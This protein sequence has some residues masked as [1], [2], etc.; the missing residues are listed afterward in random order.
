MKR[1]FVVSLF[2]AFLL[3]SSV[4]A[5]DAVKVEKGKKVK[6]D[7][8]LKVDG[9]VVE[10]SVGK[11][12]LEYTQGA[13]MIIP[14]LES[15]LEGMKVGDQKTVTVAPKDGYGEINPE[16]VK[17][18]P[19]SAFPADFTPQVGMVIEMKDEKS[20]QTVPA[21]IQEIKDGKVKLNFNHPMAGKTLVFDVKIIDIK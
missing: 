17:D 10:S 9:Q 8:T 15:Q 13:N 5:D 21:V 4:W 19:A 7:Y 20:G 3:T 12:P 6:V 18:L 11:E 1:L 14:G 2:T 16:A